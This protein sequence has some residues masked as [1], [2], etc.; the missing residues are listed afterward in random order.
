MATEEE[1]AHTPVP[2]L[3]VV[4]TVILVGDVGC[5]SF[6][7]FTKLIDARRGKLK[8]V[9]AVGLFRQAS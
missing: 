6:V 3:R 1:A 7:P 8:P 4:P 2:P 9:C 5:I